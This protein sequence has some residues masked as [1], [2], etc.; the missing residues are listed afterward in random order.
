M[1]N[2]TAGNEMKGRANGAAFH[3]GLEPI[4]AG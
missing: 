1:L 3:F 2:K 4:E